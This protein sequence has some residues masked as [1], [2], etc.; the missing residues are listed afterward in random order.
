MAPE[1]P[2]N[3]TIRTLDVAVA[4]ITSKVDTADCVLCQKR[5]IGYR[6]YPG[7]WSLPGGG[8]RESE[9]IEQCLEREM[10]KEFFKNIAYDFRQAIQFTTQSF[11]DELIIDNEQKI[12]QGT[13][14]AF[15]LPFDGKISSPSI[16]EGAGFAFLSAGEIKVYQFIPHDLK[17]LQKY[18]LEKSK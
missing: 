11:R 14:Y 13:Q 7:R 4:L 10:K 2:I 3:Q 5:G 1:Q 16:G 15:I 8:K 12:R 18:F 17:L 9:S 6:W